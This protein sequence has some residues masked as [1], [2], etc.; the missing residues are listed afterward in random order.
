MP[1]LPSVPVPSPDQLVSPVSTLLGYLGKE[2]TARRGRTRR[3]LDAASQEFRDAAL[4]V[5][6]AHAKLRTLATIQTGPLLELVSFPQV[7]RKQDELWEA[8]RRLTVA[9]YNLRR[10]GRE[11]RVRAAEAITDAL[12]L[13]G[14]GL[15]DK[16]EPTWDQQGRK[17]ADL[18]LAFDATPNRR[19]W[20]RS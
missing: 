9:Y 19:W 3:A 11:E 12:S 13:L 10:T 5:F 18:L 1:S 7:L 15:A 20:R 8:G 4:A 14:I 2:A 6:F 16:P 17:F